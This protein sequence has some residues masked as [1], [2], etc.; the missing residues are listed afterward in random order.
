MSSAEG[1]QPV[2]DEPAVVRWRVVLV[3]WLGPVVFGI[4]LN[5]LSN[6]LSP[7]A[8][9]ALVVV[10]AV[11]YGFNRLD[12]T[13]PLAKALPRVL[14]YLAVAAVALAVAT[15][16][17]WN[18]PITVVA[19]VLI[20]CTALLA[21]HRA[22][23]SG[24][25]AGIS[26]FTAGLHVLSNPPPRLHGVGDW[27]VFL[28][29]GASGTTMGLLILDNRRWLFGPGGI[30]V[31]DVRQ[32]RMAWGRGSALGIIAVVAAIAA[33]RAGGNPLVAATAMTAGLS[34]LVV[35]LVFFFSERLDTLAGAMLV[36]CGASVAG[37]GAFAFGDHEL[38]VGTVAACAGVAMAGGGFSLLDTTGVLARLR[39][40][41]ERLV[42]PAPP[43]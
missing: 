36:T 20:A 17:S 4:A 33:V 10:V 37:L 24:T 31:A 42:R 6:V 5:Q 43:A 11:V 18:G 34:W 41:L 19:I 8:V 15:P 28:A 27:L 2:P 1:S 25:L 13:A 39:A 14:L 35:S 7:V 26:I 21:P 9:G 22:V 12:A 30:T 3:R 38:L 16:T 40:W 29:I 23:A 32:W